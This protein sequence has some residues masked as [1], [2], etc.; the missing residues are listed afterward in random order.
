DVNPGAAAMG[1]TGASSSIV[2]TTLPTPVTFPGMPNPRWWTMEDGRT[3]FG[4]IRPDTT[5]LAKLL[6]IEFGLLFSNDWFLTPLTTRA[7]SLVTVTGLMVTDTF[8]ERVWIDPVDAAA[9]DERSRFSLF[10]LSMKPGGAPDPTL[11]VGAA[12]PKVQESAP[13]EAVMLVRD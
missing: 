4:A 13:F 12:A 2:R 8:G 5:D 7:G 1:A 10:T 11:L 9:P 3:N 6:F